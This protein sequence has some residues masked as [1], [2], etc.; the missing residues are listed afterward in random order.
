MTAAYPR[1]AV[2]TGA[3]SGIGAATAKLLADEGF[4]L[5]IT[6]HSDASGADETRAEVEKRGQRCEVVQQDVAQLETDDAVGELIA[7]LGG[8]GVL[9]N[10]AGTGASSP[11]LD[12]DLETWRKVVATDL[13]GAFLCAQRAARTMVEQGRGGR[14]ILVTSVHEHVPRRGAAPYCAAKA[15][16]GMFGKVLAL[17]LAEHGITVNSVAPGEVATPMTGQAEEDAWHVRRPG[18]PMG[19]PGHVVEI[20]SVI[21]FL[22]SPRSSYVT[23]SSYVV[24]GGLMLMAA[25]GH[26]DAGDEWRQP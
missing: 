20:A 21:G 4:D 25:H 23:G 10:N 6:Y 5:G 3:D 8:I 2:V 22:A 17:E 7:R 16:L 13:D 18:N 14:I 15:G 1:V 26:D 9:V 12:T 11:V 19:H 24:D